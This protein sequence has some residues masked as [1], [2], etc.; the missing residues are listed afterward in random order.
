VFGGFAIHLQISGV[1]DMVGFLDKF[2]PEA[3]MMNLFNYVPGTAFIQIVMLITILL[4]IVTLCDSMTSTVSAMSLKQFKGAKE[5]PISI[6]VFWGILIGSVSLVFVLS[7]GIGGVKIVKTIAGFP[8]VFLELAMMLGFIYHLAKG[9][10]KED[11][12]KYADAMAEQNAEIEE[13]YA[14]EAEEIEAKKAA[15]KAK[16]EKKQA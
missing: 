1:A 8:I 5:A 13:M 9:R 12:I 14:V 2:G 15:K 3:F 16:K 4:S 7:G 6:K 11:K 10:H